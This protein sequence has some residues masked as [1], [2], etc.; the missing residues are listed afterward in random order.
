[1]HREGYGLIHVIAIGRT[2][3][4]EKCFKEKEG[5]LG[6]IEAGKQRSHHES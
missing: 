1:M 3:I 2:F 4:N 6:F 5:D